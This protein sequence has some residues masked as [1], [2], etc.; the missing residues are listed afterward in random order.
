MLIA[1]FRSVVKIVYSKFVTFVMWQQKAASLSS[2][3]LKQPKAHE[4]GHVCHS[5]SLSLCLF[6]GTYWFLRIKSVPALKIVYSRKT[7]LV[8]GVVPETSPGFCFCVYV[9]MVKTR[10]DLNRCTRQTGG[11]FGK[12]VKS[13]QLFRVWKYFDKYFYNCGDMFLLDMEWISKQLLYIS[14]QLYY[15]LL[16]SCLVIIGLNVW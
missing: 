15:C 4:T 10:S 11:S 16:S 2:S 14:V 6:A 7:W 9:Y 3:R 5:R 8:S 1:Q 12:S 13:S